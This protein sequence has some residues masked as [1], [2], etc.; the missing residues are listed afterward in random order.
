MQCFEGYGF[1]RRGLRGEKL[2]RDFA[3]FY[4]QK[5]GQEKLATEDLSNDY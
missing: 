1:F 5:K 2:A 3:D 4:N